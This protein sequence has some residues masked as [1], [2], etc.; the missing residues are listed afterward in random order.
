MVVSSCHAAKEVGLGLVL[1][2]LQWQH[3]S[4]T[5]DVHPG[6]IAQKVGRHPKRIEYMPNKYCITKRTKLPDAIV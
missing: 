3:E 5:I 4:R 2:R 6:S 1:P